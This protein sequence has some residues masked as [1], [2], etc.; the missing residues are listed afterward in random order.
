MTEEE[1]YQRLRD[2][3]VRWRM[4]KRMTQAKV[5]LALGI[6]RATLAG[7]EAGNSR[8]NSYDLYKLNLRFGVFSDFLMGTGGW[9]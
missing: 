9:K 8:F 1:F 6:P 3:I 7:K 5:A 4:D 2:R